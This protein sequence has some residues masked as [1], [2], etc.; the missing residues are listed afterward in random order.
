[1]LELEDVA[2]VGA[3]EGV[4]RLVRVADHAEIPVLLGQELQQ[5]VLGMVRVLVLVDQDV[6]KCLPPA[7]AR[8][9]KAL[10]RLHR[11]HQE[12]VEIDGVRRVEAALVEAVGLRHGLVVEGGD[13]RVVLVRADEGVLRVR[14]LGVDPGG[15]EALR[16]L[17]ELLEAGLHETHLIG[18]VVDGERR[19]HAEARRLPAEDPAAGGVERHHPHR[20]HDAPEQPLE[21]GAH[22]VRRLVRERDREQ[23]R[24]VSHRTPRRGARRD[25]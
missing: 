23:S 25:R 1:M 8:L 10:Q 4:D 9:G 12:V 7:L 20:A 2:D 22:L 6:A 16:I 19:A 11:Q 14:D 15:S 18:L 3:P 5:P 17:L 24:S 13:A 21:P